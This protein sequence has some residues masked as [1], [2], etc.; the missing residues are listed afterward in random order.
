MFD[1]IT[2]GSATR[3]VFLRSKAMELHKEHGIQEACF[4]FGA[5]I[6]VEDI[7]IETGGGA[8]NNAVSFA[9]LAKLKTA[10]VA[11]VGNDASGNEIADALKRERINTSLIQRVKNVKTGYSVILLSKAA[12]RTILTYRGAASMISDDKIDWEK[13]SAKLFH[14]SSL[15][16]NLDLLN[17]IIKRAKKIGA[18][19]CFNPGSNELKQGKKILAPLF[20][21]LDIVFL[22]R[23][24]ASLLT[25]VKDADLPGIIKAMRGICAHSVVTD[26]PAGA[27]A[28]TPHETIFAGIIP[29]K[30][31]NLTGAGDAFASAYAAAMLKHNDVRTA[32]ALGSANATGVVQRMG[33][34]VGILD[35]WPTAQ[36]LAKVKI[37]KMNF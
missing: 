22:N 14:V 19:V 2:F 4:P 31:I 21:K 3:D 17:A 13:I 6:D 27:Y 10:V 11:A 18:E 12:E 7:T 24:E 33:A 23:E 9:R 36:Y 34:K 16:G 5:K 35:K 15:G 29:V 37:K 30:K 28:V 26:G 25:G 32:L 20:A 1:V 8:T